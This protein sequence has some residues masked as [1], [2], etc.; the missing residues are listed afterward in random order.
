VTFG[1]P[2]SQQYFVVTEIPKG[3]VQM[4]WPATDSLDAKVSRRV[5]MLAA[6]FN[7]RLRVKIREEM[8]DT[9]SPDAGANLSDTYKGYGHIVA[10]ATIAP[11][12]ARA[13]ADAMKAAAASLFEKGV[14]EEELVRAKQPALTAAR[15]SVRTNPYWIGSVLGAAQEQPERLEWARNRLADIESITP[16]ELTEFAHRFL[17]P[18]KASEFIS[19]PEPKKA[20]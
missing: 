12:K 19:L 15:Q 8:G 11:D 2:A 20:N 4:F 10:Q 6:V 9:Y 18:A 3:I 1:A 16:A 7:D 5:S 14:T 13:V 17:D